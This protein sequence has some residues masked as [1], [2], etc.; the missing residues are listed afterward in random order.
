MRAG[1]LE[2]ESVEVH[3]GVRQGCLQSPIIFALCADVL[4]TELHTVLRTDELVRAFADDTGV[5]ITDYEV[6]LP[7]FAETIPRIF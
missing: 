6:S 1:G 3:S 4:L 5:V 2:L 7:H